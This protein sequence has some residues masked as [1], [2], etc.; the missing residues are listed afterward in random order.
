MHIQRKSD[1]TVKFEYGT[2]LRRIY[3][4]KGIQDPLYWGSAIASVR[5]GECT[6]PHSHDEFETFIV[7]SGKGE[8]QIEAEREVMTAG[9][10][11]FIPK[12]HHHQF[13]NLS[14]EEPL[15][16]IS[17]YWDSPEAREQILGHLLQKKAG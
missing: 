16:F 9:D 15:V 5:P 6:T 13:Q 3:P 17:I 1:A 2:D 8:M 7:L 10:I 14:N 11:V 12:D 4:W